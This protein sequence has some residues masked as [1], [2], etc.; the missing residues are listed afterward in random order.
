M[1]RQVKSI[2]CDLIIIGTGMAGMA[3]ALFAARQGIDAVQVGITGELGF[4]SGPLDLLGVHPVA[5]GRILEDPWQG[6]AA[7]CRDEP[8][9]PF[10][11]LEI[12]AIRRALDEFLDF[13]QTAGYPHT[14]LGRRNLTL[15]TAAGTRKTTYAV[16]HTMQHGPE[17]LAR[18]TPC[19]LVGFEGL[20]GFSARQIALSLAAQ[21]PELRPVRIPFP[22][23]QG[24]LYTEHMARALDA[25]PARE[26]L[27]AAIR[28]HLGA[29]QCVALPAVLGLYRTIAVLADLQ[30]GLGVPVFEIPTMLP[31]VTGVRLR[32]LFEQRLPAMGIRPY[33]QQ[34][35]LGVQRLNDGRWSMSVGYA[36]AERQVVA[37]SAILC[38]GRFFGRGLHARR[39]GIQE[40]IFDLP[41]VQPM[42][43]AAWHHKDLFDSQGH[44]INRA[45]L[46]VDERFRPV[47]AQCHAIFPN[48][49]AAGSILAYQDWMRQ[50][51]GSGLAIATAYG[52]V[53]SCAGFLMPSAPT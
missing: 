24:E 39:H 26:K 25:T 7:L 20:K 12:G 14:A 23:A 33:W 46:A 21:W 28:P 43:R 30:Q 2:S 13:L 38:S 50:K 36:E 17:A 47:D 45:G 51:C 27:V 40:T 42:D 9:H 1:N 48:L 18:Q 53:Q 52:A 16:P 37:R 10:A 34:R 35:V 11:K 49:F 4:A 19:L 29:A 6:I 41:V 22:D 31:A 8:L 32:E 44:P 5:E 3:A 15:I